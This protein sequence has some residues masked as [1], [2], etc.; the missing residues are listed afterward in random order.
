M[1]ADRSCSLSTALTLTFLINVHCVIIVEGETFSKN[2]KRTGRKSSSISTAYFRASTVHVSSKMKEF[3][4]STFLNH[5]VASF[6]N[7]RFVKIM[8]I[9]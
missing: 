6:L 9:F 2:D 8:N 3:P 1:S 7:S 5:F 4:K